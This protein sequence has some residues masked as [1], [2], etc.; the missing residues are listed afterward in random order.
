MSLWTTEGVEITWQLRLQRRVGHRERHWL[1]SAVRRTWPPHGLPLQKF[2][3]LNKVRLDRGG[4]GEDVGSLGEERSNLRTTL[5]IRECLK[6]QVGEVSRIPSNSVGRITFSEI[7]QRQHV[8]TEKYNSTNKVDRTRTHNKTRRLV[9]NALK[10][11]KTLTVVEKEF[12]ELEWGQKAIAKFNLWSVCK[13]WGRS[14]D[15]FRRTWSKETELGK[16]VR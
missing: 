12:H 3:T 4:L 9:L 5:K 14:A 2:I 8:E 11:T 6:K 13:T 15:D 10:G 7:K 1:I 16:L